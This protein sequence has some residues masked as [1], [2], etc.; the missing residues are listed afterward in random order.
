MKRKKGGGGRRK[1]R[2]PPSLRLSH[3]KIH[4]TKRRPSLTYH[5]RTV[6]YGISLQ[7]ALPYIHLM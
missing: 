1:V 3:S 5:L 4:E 6:Y 7:Y 2:D